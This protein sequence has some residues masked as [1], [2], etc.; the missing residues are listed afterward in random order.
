ML[1]YD[2]IISIEEVSYEEDTYNLHIEN[3][4]NYYA[5]GILVSNCHQY[6]AKTLQ[7]LSIR[8]SNCEYRI[9]TTGTVQDEKVSKLQLEGSFG[10]VFKT[11]STK[12]LM[13]RKQ[14]AKLKIKCLILEHPKDIA[15]MVRKVD[16]QKEMNYIV[17]DEKRN[18][19]IANLAKAT[20]G[21]TLVLFQY[22][23]K[24]GKILYELIKERCPD[25]KVFYISGETKTDDREDIR[26]S[27]ANYDNAII[28][29][30]SATVATGTNIP[31]IENIIFSS[32]TKSK[33]RNLQ[34]IGRGIRLA[35]D[36][37]FCTLFDIGDDFSGGTKSN[38][39]TFGHFRERLDIYNNEEFDFSITTIKL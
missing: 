1:I 12:E 5:N 18:R 36:K 28:V 38:G 20:N 15:K 33:I 7:D 19:F 10:P 25:K 23:E 24:H 17:R 2:D 37:D 30:S 35:P 4:H 13:D 32:P 8:L 22:V 31:S 26:T 21:N 16:Y 34:S 27:M 11:I 3:N 6:V 29:A 14:V 9:G 39:Y